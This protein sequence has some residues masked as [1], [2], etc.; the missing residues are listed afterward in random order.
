MSDLEEALMALLEENSAL[1][2]AAI[3]SEDNTPTLAVAVG[4]FVQV[5]QHP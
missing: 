4:H 1:N 2:R 5:G 3:R